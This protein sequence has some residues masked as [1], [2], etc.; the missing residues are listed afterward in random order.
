[1]REFSAV[2]VQL[3]FAPLPIETIVFSVN[4]LREGPPGES[5]GWFGS[6]FLIVF[7][8]QSVVVSSTEESQEPVLDVPSA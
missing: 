6:R 3:F 8:E 1:V 7:G 5:E 4:L 2:I